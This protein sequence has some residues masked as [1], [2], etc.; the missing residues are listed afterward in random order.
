M[1]TLEVR[2]CITTKPMEKINQTAVEWLEQQINARGPI[3]EDTPT[4][5]KEL[6][7]QAKAMEKEQIEDA[8][9]DGKWDWSE[10]I[11]KGIESK[12]LA[13]YYQETYGKRN[14]PISEGVDQ[15]ETYPE[16]RN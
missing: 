4:W 15:P 7:E 2:N 1:E 10:H 12:D 8:F 9:Q 3:G 5:L 16:G 11:E 14:T 13:Q 6:Y